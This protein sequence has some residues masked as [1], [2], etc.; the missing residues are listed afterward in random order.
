MRLLIHLLKAYHLSH[1]N[2]KLFEDND[3]LVFV[4]SLCLNGVW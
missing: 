3:Y 1:T 2:S 4:E